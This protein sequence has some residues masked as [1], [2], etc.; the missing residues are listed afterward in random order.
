[1]TIED[2]YLRLRVALQST[3]TPYAFIGAMGAIAWGRPRATTDLDLVVQCDERSFALLRDALIASGFEE[4][5]GVGGAEEGDGLPDIAIFWAGAQPA[6]R[7]DVFIAKLDFEREVVA[8]A[9][10]VHLLGADVPIARPEAMLVYKLLASRPKDLID[11]DAI[12]E[13]RALAGGVIDWALV[14]R[15]ASVWGI[16]SKVDALRNR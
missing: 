2:V 5:K 16:E 10:P 3:G 15:W 11:I 7:V 1:M 9:L 12:L 4:G 6:V 14:L 13:G 8:T